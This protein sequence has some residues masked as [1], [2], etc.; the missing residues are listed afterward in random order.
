MAL[1]ESLSPELIYALKGNIA[2]PNTDARTAGTVNA[3]AGTRLQDAA[4][5]SNALQQQRISAVTI[6]GTVKANQ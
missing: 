3:Q 5:D 1:V 4:T 6:T 2:L